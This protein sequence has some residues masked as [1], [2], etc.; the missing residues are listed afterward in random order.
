MKIDNLHSENPSIQN[1]LVLPWYLNFG[2]WPKD[3]IGDYPVLTD[4]DPYFS[5]V[6]TSPTINTETFY[7]PA[8]ANKFDKQVWFK[9]SG[10][11]YKFILEVPGYGREHLSVEIEGD[12]L[13]IK[14]E[15]PVGENVG[16]CFTER[17]IIPDDQILDLGMGS[18][19]V[20]Y[21]VLTIFFPV[22]SL[23]KPQSI[24]LL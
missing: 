12:T 22:L 7:I 20:E 13:V 11:A 15:K 10:G 19:K 18:V 3:Y 1:C 17:Y 6:T 23:P 16:H 24:K 8:P 9:E 2:H 21:G 4:I 14:A 5:R